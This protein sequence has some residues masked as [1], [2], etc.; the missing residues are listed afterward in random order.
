MRPAPAVAEHERSEP[1][2]DVR[3]R[4]ECGDT[5]QPPGQ[6]RPRNVRRGQ[7]QERE[8]QQEARVTA[9]GFPVLSAIA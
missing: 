7:E 8:E 5:V 1:L 6:L 2:E 4:V 3:D 9:A